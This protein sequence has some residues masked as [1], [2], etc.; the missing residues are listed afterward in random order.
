MTIEAHMT[1]NSWARVFDA[2]AILAL[3]L[4]RRRFFDGKAKISYFAIKG[5]KYR[6][7]QQIAAEKHHQYEM[8]F[9]QIDQKLLSIDVRQYYCGFIVYAA[10]IW[11][12]I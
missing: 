2:P 5:K 10:G 6:F 12:S 9:H 8:W 3:D 4:S 11:A 1:P 7:L